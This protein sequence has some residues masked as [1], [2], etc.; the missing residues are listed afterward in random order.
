MLD[1]WFKRTYPLKHLKKWLYWPWADYRVLR[2][3][4][5]VLFTSNQERI[6]ARESFWLYKATEIVSGYGTSPPPINTA[7]QLKLLFERF[8]QLQG[9]RIILFMGRIHPKKGV[10]I[11]IEAFGQVANNENR[12]HLLIAGPDEVGLKLKLKQRAD[13]LGIAE[14]WKEIGLIAHLSGVGFHL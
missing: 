8:P 1:S 4:K 2:D 5:A 7:S 12:L 13:A 3:A 14:F 10:D 6:S 11:L 9:K